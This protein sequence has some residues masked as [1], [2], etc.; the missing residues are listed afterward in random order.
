MK[1]SY[2]LPISLIVLGL[3]IIQSLSSLS[4]TARTR[5]EHGLS[6]DAPMRLDWL[7]MKSNGDAPGDPVIHKADEG[8]PSRALA[9]PAATFTVT[10]TGDSGAGSL[11]QAILDANQNSGPDMIGF[12]IGAGGVQTIRPQAPL[13]TITDP[14]TIDATTQ[15]GFSGTPLIEL[16]GS[17][18]GSGTYGLVINTE[19]S[20]VK[21]L[22]IGNFGGGGI[23]LVQLGNNMI[24]NNYLGTDATCT[25]NRGNGGE[26]VTILD[27]NANTVT[28]NTIV[29]N[30]DGGSV[31]N[32]ND[33][34]IRDN[35]LG[36]DAT[37]TRN[38]G[39]TGAGF[40]FANAFNN[41][42]EGNRVAFNQF[43]FIGFGGAGNMFGG[44]PL[45]GN[46]IGLNGTGIQLNNSN[47]N[48]FKG[49][50]IG[51]NS[52]GDDLGN[53]G[54]GIE[55]AG[56]SSNNQIGGATPKQ[57]N[58]I[59]FNQTG[60]NAFTGANSNLYLLNSIHSNALFGINNNGGANR[61]INPPQLIS[62]TASASDTLITGRF[63]GLP[64]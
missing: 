13:P 44:D 10:N 3:L 48:V 54:A 47:G 8:E 9:Q 4:A 34:L 51:T 35:N 11:R 27:S 52:L 56:T 60:I 14:V 46:T 55:L 16:D 62:A 18:A 7:P 1:K 64:F 6:A 29:F 31:I 21:G 20:V 37:M 43:G 41:R 61:N 59:A 58:T 50:F 39:N 63:F 40:G 38:K 25:E 28:S 23:R 2:S 17:N 49:N 57:G 19:N 12:N 53:Q 22:A 33:N 15:P 42:F 32:S 5:S 36:T 26:G 30:G 45:L 24:M